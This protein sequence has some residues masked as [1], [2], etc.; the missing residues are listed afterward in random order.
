[1]YLVFV[2]LQVNWS[3]PLFGQ[4][5]K[6]PPAHNGQPLAFNLGKVLIKSENLKA[7]TSLW[8]ASYQSLLWM[9]SSHKWQNTFFFNENICNR[10]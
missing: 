6:G 5:N 8:F 10:K 1:M 3:G 4:S 7:Q 9:I 2:S